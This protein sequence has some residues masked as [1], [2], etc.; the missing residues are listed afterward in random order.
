[1]DVTNA[2]VG[3]AIPE[4]A[5]SRV[6]HDATLEIFKAGM[7][8]AI[9]E[10]GDQELTPWPVISRDTEREIHELLEAKLRRAIENLHAI[11]AVQPSP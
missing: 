9:F 5:L 8:W 4:N 10:I 3:Q 1:M 2:D 11:P 6:C 7:E